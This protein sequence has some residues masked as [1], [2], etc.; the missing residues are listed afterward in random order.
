MK[1]EQLGWYETRGGECALVTAINTTTAEVQRGDR[2]GQ[3]YIDGRYYSDRESDYDLVAPWLDKPLPAW[4]TALQSAIA[5]QLA[6][7]EEQR[8]AWLDEARL[9]REE[10]EER[11]CD[12]AV[13][14]PTWSDFTLY[15]G[16]G[17]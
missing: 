16:I 15:A 2:Q 5:P 13:C 7:V 6:S 14:S 8:C 11:A 3:C 1:I 9:L 12:V 4:A 10:V 17:R